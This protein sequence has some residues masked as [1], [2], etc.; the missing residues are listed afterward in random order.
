MAIAKEISVQY[1]GAKKVV[2]DRIIRSGHLRISAADD[3]LSFSFCRVKAKEG[4]VPT[5]V[6]LA[7]DPVPNIYLLLW[8]DESNQC[9]GSNMLQLLHG[10]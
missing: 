9:L 6:I 10:C 5:W 8:S 7:P 3:G 4:S 2:W 1:T